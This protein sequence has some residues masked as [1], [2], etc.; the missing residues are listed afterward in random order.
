MYSNHLG[1]IQKNFSI[2]NRIF[3]ISMSLINL[4]KNKYKKNFIPLTLEI[5]NDS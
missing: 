4:G 3:V 5:S 2:F 1:I